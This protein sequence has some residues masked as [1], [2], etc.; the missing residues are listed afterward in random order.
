MIRLWTIILAGMALTVAGCG[1][2][3]P[4]P[5]KVPIPSPAKKEAKVPAAAE[6]APSPAAAPKAPSLAE[7]KQVEPPP[8]VAYNYNPQGKPDPFKPLV[9][10]PKEVSPPPPRK[11]EAAERPDATPL[12]RI[13]VGQIKLVALVWG[14]SEPRALV[15]TPKGEGFIIA[16]GTP[17]GKNYGTVAQIT[18]AGVVIA[19]K[20]E[21]SPGKFK[22]QER[23]LKLYQE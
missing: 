3:P 17:I 18:S 21:T 2:E 5:T 13:D 16:L 6:K 4:K 23:T 11:L 8:A 15:E 10:E 7:E 22:T 1:G 12:E 9:E 14:I 19:E 20:L